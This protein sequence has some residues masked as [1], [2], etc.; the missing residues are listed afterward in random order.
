MGRLYAGVL[1]SLAMAVVLCRGVKDSSGVDGSLILA[2]IS[3]IIFAVMG[4]VLGHIA[5]L[6]VDESVRLKMEREL[7][8][9][10]VNEQGARVKK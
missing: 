2:T 6:T 1:G 5:Q 4:A 8:A 7:A 10:A 3:M 9:S